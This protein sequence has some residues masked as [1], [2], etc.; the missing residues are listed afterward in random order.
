MNAALETC[1]DL[2]V[3]EIFVQG[4]KDTNG[5]GIGDLPGVIEKVDYIRDLGFNAIWLG[6][7]WDSP[8][9]DGGYDVRDY[10]MVAPR[11]GTMADLRQ[12]IR[13]LH[14]RDMKLILDLVPGHT[15]YQHQWFQESCKL[16]QNPYTDRYIWTRST[17][18]KEPVPEHSY[19]NGFVH[20]DGN[21]MTN[22]FY[23]Q[24][25]L[26]YGFYET[27]YPW[28]QKMDDPAPRATKEAIVDVLRFYYDIGADGLR[29]DMANS[30]IK[31]D[32]EKKGIAAFWQEIRGMLDREYPGKFLISEWSDPETSIDAG[33]HIDMLIHF[34]NY[35]GSKLMRHESWADQQDHGPDKHSFFRAEGKGDFREFLDPYLAMR[36]KARGKGYLTIPIG[37]HDIPRISYGRSMEELKVLYTFFYT[38]DQVPFFYY[39]DEIGLEY[40]AGAPDIEHAFNRTGARNCMHWTDGENGGFSAAKELL[41]P[42]G[43]V[44]NN[45]AEQQADPESLLNYL[46]KLLA[47]RRSSPAFAVDSELSFLYAEKGQY[48]VIYKRS[49]GK[50]SY[51]VIINPKD[52]AFTFDLKESVSEVLADRIQI[53]GTTAAI[54]PVSYGIFKVVHA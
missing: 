43:D 2:L 34:N 22:F 53:D 19:I 35:I 45:V 51:L 23:C 49:D 54:G 48:P 42:I 24:P 39:G 20:R 50:E 9:D 8:W 21:F 12:L 4:F 46:K 44:Q 5:D 7:I 36:E 52:E 10:Y 40:V 47:V 11:Y 37:N 25:A 14:E 29:V 13:M 15:S 3:Y 16:S 31:R 38:F 41:M 17:W 33:F 1:K 26:N 28:E 18:E 27:K 6:P 32:P 30:L